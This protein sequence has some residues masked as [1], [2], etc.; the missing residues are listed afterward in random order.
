MIASLRASLHT[1]RVHRLLTLAATLLVAGHAS[2]AEQIPISTV[3]IAARTGYGVPIGRAAR[4]VTMADTL[5]GKIPLHL[6]GGYRFRDRLMLGAYVEFAYGVGDPPSKVFCEPGSLPACS[7]RDVRVGAQAHWHFA[8]RASADPWLGI[9]AG[10]EVLLDRGHN[11]SI[12]GFELGNV[13]AG[14]DF[15]AGGELIVG[16]FAQLSLG[17]YNASYLT[18]EWQETRWSIDQKAVHGWLT[19][20]VRAGFRTLLGG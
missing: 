9:G 19:F 13:Q 12:R 8:P 7:M 5:A 16:P 18:T 15:D 11:T 4:S 17:I 14:V 2:A 10:Y 6:E 1:T 20:G 3:E